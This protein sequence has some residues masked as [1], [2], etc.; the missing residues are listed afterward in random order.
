MKKLN[1]TTASVPQLR[2]IKVLQ[3]GSGNFLRGFADWMIDLLNEQTD[4]N[5]A[6][7]I[8]QSTKSGKGDSIN[9]QEGLY[10]LVIN[11]IKN[12]NPFE[13]TRLIT[14]VNGAIN[15]NEDYRQFLKFA[16]SDDLQLIFSNTTEVGIAFNANDTLSTVAETF[17]GK[18]TALLY[19][20]FVH[21]KGTNDKG[22]CIIPCE[23]IERNGEVLR[24]I[25]HQYIAHWKLPNA[26]AEWIDQHN[27]FCNTLVDRIV[28]GFPKDKIND[29]QQSIGYDDKLVVTAE[30]FHLFAI[31]APEKVRQVFAADKIGLNVK[32]VKDLTPYRVSKVRILNG[33]HTAMF[34][35][36]YFSGF[37]TVKESVDDKVIGEFI[38]K[39][40]FDE[41]IPTLDLPKE[42]LQQF[43][44][45]VIERF[46]NPFI[47]HE[48]MSISMNSISK[49]KV[50]IVPTVLRYIELKKQLPQNLLYSFAALIRFYKGE[51]K[52][53]R[54]TLNDTPEV[55]AFFN[56]VWNSNDVNHVVHETL[57]NKDFWGIDL[58]TL[59]GIEEKIN[60]YLQQLESY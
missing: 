46:Q 14:S 56:K 40:I 55:I 20:R 9:E 6:I 50:R 28:P 38:R 7:Q 37:R 4:F 24:Q 12:G 18:L 36:A 58:T 52:G 32:Y 44:N 30:P 41:I 10:H 27:F 19:H 11:G 29:I 33:S 2:A 51:W 1:R 13:E 48:L 26:F 49:F 53:E 42:E 47:R 39:E 23:L 35:V 16:E 15:P 8:V 43:A 17:P 54:I 34:P 25:V 21:F 59:T 3:F 5:G 60:N 57:S 22:L 31:E 45:D